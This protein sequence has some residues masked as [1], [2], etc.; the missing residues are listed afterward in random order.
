MIN[1]IVTILYYTGIAFLGFGCVQASDASIVLRMQDM[2]HEPI[3]QTM[4]KAPFIL[5]VELKN[6]E[7]YS[8]SHVMQYIPGIENFK[9]SQSMTSHNVS[10]D[11]GK[12][13]VKAFYNFVL[14]ADKKGNF[15]VG[16]IVLKDKTGQHIRSN[17]LIIP[18]GDEI[19]ATEKSQKE[20]FFMTTTLNKKEAYVGEKLTLNI[21]FYDRLFVDDLHLQF[22]EFKNMHIITK[23]NNVAKSSVILKEE[24]YSVT[25]WNFD[26][27]PTEAGSLVIHGIQAAFFAPELGNKFKLG[28]AFDFFRS[29]HKSEQAIIAK[30]VKAEIMM[31]PDSHGLSPISAVGQF[32]KF[33]IALHQDTAAVGQGV[34]LTMNLE[35]NANFEMMDPF[36]LVLPEGCKYYD[37][38]IVSIDPERSSKRSECIIQADKPGVYTIPAQSI[39]YFDPSVREY[40]KIESNELTLTITPSEAK[41]VQSN[42]QHDII[43]QQAGEHGQNVQ[44]MVQDFTVLPYK[45]NSNFHQN[46]IPILW[47]TRLLSLLVWAWILLLLYYYGMQQ[48]V[49]KLAW[50]QHYMLFYTAE[51]MCKK[52]LLKNDTQQLRT[53]FTDLFARL[54]VVKSGQL[55]DTM[56]IDYLRKKDVSEEKIIAWQQFYAQ[57]LHVEFSKNNK[58]A[59]L[60]LVRKSLEWIEFL[61]EKA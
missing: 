49:Y 48:Y 4:C 16:P 55:H 1:I 5:Q 33:T 42:H 36:Q 40:K 31:L 43:T 22:P 59:D 58:Q 51:K 54:L 6:V 35:G 24:E 37:S 8:D 11:N 53:I 18:V 46:M 32:S 17:R 25:E 30:P 29:L 61:K 39:Y 3:K 57:L 47:Y 28:G 7:G 34:V 10:I 41:H 13:T 45:K 21:K 27:Y 50:V 14:R 20:K 19:I 2:N 38:N 26:V 12:K 9:S 60:S 23:H 52:A 15:T 56:M 44:K